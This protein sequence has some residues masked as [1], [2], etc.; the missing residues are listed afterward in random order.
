VAEKYE[1]V[2]S[3][4]PLLW[5]AFPR[6]EQ[7]PAA[8]AYSIRGPKERVHFGAWWGIFVHRFLE[9]CQTRGRRAALA[10]VGGK[11][12][13]GLFQT[14]ASI[15]VDALPEGQVELA[16]AFDPVTGHAEQVSR[17]AR[18]TESVQYGIADLLADRG[19]PWVV[20]YKTGEAPDNPGEH[21]QLLGAL[22][23]ARARWSDPWSLSPPGLERPRYYFSSFAR[24]F[25]SGEVQFK[26]AHLTDAHLDKFQQ[27]AR[28]V[29]LA[30]LNWRQRLDHG[31]PI[32]YQAGPAC[33][34]CP[35][36]PVCPA[37]AE[38][39]AGSAGGVRE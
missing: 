13:K 35:L 14:C 18:L 6:Y 9:Y 23:A 31:E 20:D 28:R 7:C 33:G 24:V 11:K 10:Y 29:H 30:V 26:T 22:I 5:T 37:Y 16:Q 32:P 39:R 19:G 15:D 34:S 1:L 38:A 3:R 25:A 12:L 17:R 2:R 4:S 21:P 36:S 27:R 8:C